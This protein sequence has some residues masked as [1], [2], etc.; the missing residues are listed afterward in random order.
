M[1]PTDQR[2][3]SFPEPPRPSSE[4]LRAHTW[5][6]YTLDHDEDAAA[7]AFAQ[8]YGAPPAYILEAWGVLYVGPIPAAQPAAGMP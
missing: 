4:T 7:R 1:P 6:A 2:P 3:L 5:R 8:L